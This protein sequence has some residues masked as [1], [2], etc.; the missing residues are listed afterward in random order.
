[1]ALS[2][3]ALVSVVCFLSVLTLLE[4]K[5]QRGTLKL[6]G[7]TDELSNAQYVSKFGYSFGSSEYKIRYRVLESAPETTATKVNL[8]LILD[9][10]WP[11]SE[12]ALSCN[13]RSSL[14]RKQAD[15]ILHERGEWSA[16]EVGSVNQNV[17]PHI[18][19][20][21]TS[22]CDQDFSEAPLHLEYEILMNQADGS[23]F[24]VEMQ[25]MMKVNVI[26]LVC[27]IA[28][29]AR[30]CSRCKAFFASAGQLH[31]VIWALSS[32]ILLQF[33]AQSL[34]TLH[35]SMYQSNGTGS[36][37][38]D[39]LSEVLFMLSQVMQTTLL[40]AIAM[41]YTLLPSRNDCIGVVRSI[42]LASLM[43]HITLVSFSKIQDESASKNHEHGGA[44]G[45][46]LL[47]VRVML[48]VWFLFATQASQQEGGLRLHDFLQR[49]R[50]AG[51][52][53]FLAY[54]VL[55]VVVQIFADYLQHPILQIGLIATQTISN[56]CLAELFLSRGTYFKV[57]TLS[58]SSLPGSRGAF[59]KMS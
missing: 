40:I 26:V 8:V 56:V 34:H 42:F 7:R 4:G 18:W 10:D 45:W 1:M 58:S 47:S 13:S 53:Y 49:F 16:W 38:L 55:L 23:E 17:R 59:D 29:L 41:G 52:V 25:G 5:Q 46:V 57:S 32:A 14:T 54:P 24:S 36:L 51:S 27:L 48:F 35:L 43:I 37:F 3:K 39:W 20:F 9:E 2:L 31:P 19:Y 30:Y 28:F 15:V 33:A 44:V 11:Q 22:V 21:V 6:S 12:E 50:I